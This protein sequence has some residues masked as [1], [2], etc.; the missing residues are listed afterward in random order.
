M[1]GQD[2][3]GELA[4]VTFASVAVDNCQVA[5]PNQHAPLFAESR[6]SEYWLFCRS[7]RHGS[8][9]GVERDQLFWEGG[10]KPQVQMREVS[11]EKKVSSK[12]RERR[13]THGALFLCSALI[14][15]TLWSR[16]FEVEMV[17]FSNEPLWGCR[18]GWWSKKRS[19][20]QDSVSLAR[21]THAGRQAG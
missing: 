19:I 15:R 7:N 11:T 20:K 1:S 10:I 21:A 12:L 5:M 17:W 4:S 13:P 14:K 18:V 2:W 8:W 16:G 3:V 9:R 6:S